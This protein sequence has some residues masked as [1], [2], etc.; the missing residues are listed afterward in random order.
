[1]VSC[2]A[3]ALSVVLIALPSTGSAV[4]LP[5]TSTLSAGLCTTAT[6]CILVGA[7]SSGFGAVTSVTAAQNQDKEDACQ[8]DAQTVGIAIAAFEAENPGHLPT[9]SA[10]WKAGLLGKHYVGGPF[11]QKWPNENASYYTLSVAGKASGRTTGDEVKPQNGDVIVDN[12]RYGGRTYDA[13]VNP[14]SACGHMLE[15]TAGV[16]ASDTSVT[17]IS[18]IACPAGSTTC[19]GATQNVSP[20]EGAV[21]AIDVTDRVQPTF[22]ATLPVPAA[23]AMSGIA[24]PTTVLC[25]AVGSGPPSAGIVVPIATGTLGTTRTLASTSLRGIACTSA[26]RCL[27]V[28][29][30]LLTGEGIVVPIELSGSTVTLGTAFDV[31]STTTISALTCP[32]SNEC[33]ATGYQ[34]DGGLVVS[35]HVTSGVP[36]PGPAKLVPTEAYQLS[37][38]ACLGAGACVAVGADNASLDDGVIVGVSQGRG[39]TTRAVNGALGFSGVACAGTSL[40]YGIGPGFGAVGGGS[41]VPLPPTIT[42]TTSVRASADHATSHHPVVLIARVDPSPSAGHVTFTSDGAVI[43]GCGAVHAV[44][45]SARCVVAFPKVGA[46]VL[47]ATYTGDAIERSS[48]SGATIVRVA[49]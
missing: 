28:G 9:T 4:G 5:E 22:S 43:A 48:I 6:S 1:M 15:P 7:D 25:V 23:T 36:T 2:A 24:C 17:G 12:V 16:E 39:T 34:V 37:S 11:L 35:I 26:T 42:T 30:D 13:T 21:V 45:G 33:I 41:I 47:R 10:G 3:L 44:A 19:Y 32:A 40:C 29:A 8:S 20:Q 46:V 27:A 49:T 38:I 31:P 14:V 18:A